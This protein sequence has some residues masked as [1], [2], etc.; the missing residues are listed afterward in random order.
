MYIEIF[1]IWYL[2]RYIKDFPKEIASQNMWIYIYIYI[3]VCVCVLLYVYI[4]LP[5]ISTIL[6]I[7][8]NRLNINITIIKMI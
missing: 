7:V 8:F 2:D 1:N 5:I 4:I 6:K 3:Y